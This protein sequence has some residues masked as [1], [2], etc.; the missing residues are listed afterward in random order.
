MDERCLDGMV[1]GDGGDDE[2]KASPGGIW[3]RRFSSYLNRLPSNLGGLLAC[4]DPLGNGWNSELG[5]S[6]RWGFGTC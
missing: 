6:G 5:R 2:A 4:P 1:V 3:K